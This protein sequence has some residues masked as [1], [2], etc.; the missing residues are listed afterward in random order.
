MKKLL[1][2]ALVLTGT[3]LALTGLRN[4]F[5]LN[6]TSTGPTTVCGPGGG[7]VSYWLVNPSGSTAWGDITGTLATQTDLQAV[8]DGKRNTWTAIAQADVTDLTTDLGL[9]YDKAGGEITGGV[10]ISAPATI[11][12]ILTDAVTA[13]NVRSGSS[14]F[15]GGVSFTAAVTAASVLAGGVTATNIQAGASTFT[16]GV[17]HTAAVTTISLA[18]GSITCSGAVSAAGST[19]ASL[20]SGAS[21]FT[22]AVSMGGVSIAGPATYYG[23]TLAIGGVTCIAAQS[24]VSNT[25]SETAIVTTT[26]PTNTLR[27]GTTF[28]YSA[29]IRH[30]NQA[31]SGILTFRMYVGGTATQ[32]IVMA[33]QTGALANVPAIFEG[34]ATIRTTGAGGTYIGTG[35]YQI[36]STATAV[37]Q[38]GQVGTSTAAVD[39]TAATPTVRLTAQ[40]ATSSTTNYLT[41]QNA[42]I[43]QVNF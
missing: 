19:F 15:T 33:T 40:W 25:S 8:L 16:G 10:S 37:I 18:A 42:C 29:I 43:E 2:L 31:T 23:K 35:H 28:R 1:I 11:D 20:T 27:A 36:M 17:T 24:A 26:I 4:A 6:V 13:T 34:K 12:S 32:T 9:K 30:N 21:T 5:A 3:L 39:T 7:P 22:G 14:T 41:I 38:Y